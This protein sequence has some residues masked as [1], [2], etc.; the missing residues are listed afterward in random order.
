MYPLTSRENHLAI[1]KYR[2]LRYDSQ[3]S[4]TSPTEIEIIE[5]LCNIKVYNIHKA[6]RYAIAHL[7]YA[8]CLKMNTSSNVISILLMRKLHEFLTIRFGVLYTGQ[9][10][11]VIEL[12]RLSE[13]YRQSLNYVPYHGVKQI[14]KIRKNI[15]T[16]FREYG[17]E[18]EELL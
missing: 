7:R 16:T 11:N 5:M 10:H 13:R 12:R 3:L 17:I 2:S 18:L 15:M 14:L 8:I 4:F 6:E 9:P 1:S